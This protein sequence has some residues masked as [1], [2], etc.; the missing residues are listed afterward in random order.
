MQNHQVGMLGDKA[1]RRGGRA[2][3]IVGKL[4]VGLVD[5]DHA[6]ARIAQG[7]DKV[8]RRHI[9][10]GIVG[11]GHDRK[12]APG[13]GREH[14]CLVELKGRRIAPHVAHLGLT[15]RRKERVLAKARRAVEQGPPRAAKRQQVVIEQLVAAVSHADVL[16]RHAMPDSQL[17]AQVVRHGIGIAVERCGS[18]GR[19]DRLAH[20]GGHG[21]GVLVGRKIDARGRKVGIVG[22]NT[23]Q[24]RLDE[25]LH[26]GRQLGHIRPP[27]RSCQRHPRLQP[28]SGPRPRQP[29]PRRRPAR[30]P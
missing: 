25:L 28:P 5:H 30:Q 24:V 8:E 14:S 26:A 2:K 4:N 19:I 21:I 29:S 27:R 3:R 11:R 17:V 20:A 1:L 18:Q 10:R 7:S 23:G 13:C 15:E 6:G 12:V 22:L 9:A 16:A